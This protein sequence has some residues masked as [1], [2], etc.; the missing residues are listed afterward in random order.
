ME[1]CVRCRIDEKSVKLFDGIYDGRMSKICERCSII[2]NIP[3]IRKPAASQLRDSE[4]GARVYERMKRISGIRDKK[5]GETFFIEDKLDELNKKPELELPEGD[6]LNLIEFYHWE[7]M[8]NRRRKGLSQ[9]K[10]AAALGESVTA[11]KMIERAKLPENADSLINKLEQFFQIKLKR[12]TETERIFKE[13]ELR[14]KFRSGP[15]LLDENGHELEKIPESFIYEKEPEMIEEDLILEEVPKRIPSEVHCRVETKKDEETHLLEGGAVVECRVEK[16]H[17]PEKIVKEEKP[18][19]FLRVKSYPPL[20]SEELEEDVGIEASQIIKEK[21]PVDLK[22]DKNQ[23]FDIKKAGVSGVTIADLKD[24]H[25][26]KI[27]VTKQ[28]Q[29][30]EKKRIEERTRLIEARKEEIRLKKEKESEELDS[31]LGGVELLEDL[32]END[33]FEKKKEFD[34][35][36][37]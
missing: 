5:Q 29:I 22:L 27:E 10:L 13:R 11:V 7:I 1:K 34:E 31:V 9:E 14:K 8:K 24:L 18:R 32:E 23:E 17:V 26:K 16:Q 2:E 28:E 25:R 37:I 19:R 4:S 12:L 35:E 36:L 30:E 3:I 15:V 20:N 6:K 33:G 21:K